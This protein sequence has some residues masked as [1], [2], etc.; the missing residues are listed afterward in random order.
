MAQIVATFR[1]LPKDADVDLNLMKEEV[2]ET[3]PIDAS[4]YRFDEEPIAFGLVALIAHV[5]VPEDLAGGTEAIE[6]A[7]RLLKTAGEVDVTMVRRV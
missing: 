4:V 7:I 5:V 3:L 1:I 6:R 2:V